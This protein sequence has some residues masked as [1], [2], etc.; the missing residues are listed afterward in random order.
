[1]KLK[2]TQRYNAK[3]PAGTELEILDII[4]DDKFSSGF[5]LKVILNG[6]S[7]PDWLTIDWFVK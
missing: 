1:M 4:R 3:N 5:G 6:R 7:A 2:L